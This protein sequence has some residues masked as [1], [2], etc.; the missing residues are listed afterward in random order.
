MEEKI[1]KINERRCGGRAQR[2]MEM[3]PRG[4]VKHLPKADEKSRLFPLRKG[5]RTWTSV[6]VSELVRKEAEEA[7]ETGLIIFSTTLEWNLC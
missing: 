3:D 7:V 1:L 4:E 2:L 5:S 6:H